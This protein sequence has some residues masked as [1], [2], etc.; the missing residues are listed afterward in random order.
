MVG[1]NF[2]VYCVPVMVTLQLKVV[3][4]PQFDAAVRVSTAGIEFPA[5]RIV[6]CWFQD[7]VNERVAFVGFQLFAVMV[8]VSGT[9]PVFL[10]YTVWVPVPP[11]LM[12]PTFRVVAA[13][14][15][16]LSEYTPTFTAFIVPFRGNDLV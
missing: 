16:P 9:L 15:H 12:F 3:M 11:G 7:S 5:G 1:G 4:D 8:R 2:R 10:M 13:C 14:V 6:S